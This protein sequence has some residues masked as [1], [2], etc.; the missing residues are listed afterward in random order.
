MDFDEIYRSI[1]PSEKSILEQVDEYT[2]YCYYTGIDPLV[3]GKAHNAPYRKDDIP[4][5]SVYPSKNNFV[6][7]M[8][9]DHT[10]SESGTIF[11]LI[12]KLES[13]QSTN[14]VLGRINEDFGLGY[15]INNPAR[16]N[17]IQWY[18]K[19]TINPIKIK[20]VNQEFT[21][22]GTK[23]WQ[24]FRI[25][26]DLL[27]LYNTT[28]VKYYWSYEGQL[29]P[30]TANDPTFAYR[31]GEYYQLYA[32]FNSKQYK[33][34]NNLPE[35]Y[36]F[37]YLQLPPTGNR[38]IIDKSSKDVIFCRRLGYDAVSGKSETTFLPHKKVLELKERFNEIYI[39]L[40]NDIPGK[41]MVEKYVKEYPFL[42][43]RFLPK[44]KDK[45]DNCKAEG[46]EATEQL[47]RD[48][49]Q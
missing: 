44:H 3:L 34:R 14:E 38:L 41:N 39:M 20:V 2:L 5:F 49:I 6:E 15:T 13:L 11:Q 45:T 12:K 21:E 35:N 40:D 31:I 32:P 28:Q 37:G 22:A 8:W 9:K 46:F 18:D 29:A 24:Q 25:G 23:F 30:T 10:T 33:F 26:N 42:K 19:P 48:L 17:K 7:Y 47:M 36:F 4:S 27:D 1:V 16:A 43:A